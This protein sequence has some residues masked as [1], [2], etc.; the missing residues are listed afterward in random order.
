M[1]DEG[2][3]ETRQDGATGLAVAAGGR[4]LVSTAAALDRRL[5]A[6]DPAAK[7]RAPLRRVLIDCSEVAALDTV[8]AWLMLRLEA[9]FGRTGA[10][11]SIENLPPRFAPLLAQAERYTAAT[12][13]PAR[14]ARQSEIISAIEWVGR[15]AIAAWHEV[16]AGFS[17]FGLVTLTTLRI[18]R[19][20]SRFRFT[21]FVSHVQ[22]TGLSALPIVG[23][24]SFLIGVV[25]AY[26]G[27]TQLR[28]FGAEIFTVNLLGIGYLRELG[29]LMTAIIV[30]GRSGSSFTAEIGTMRVN[31]EVDAMTTLGLDPIEV[32][33]VPRLAALG[34]AL[35]LLTFYANI[36]GL[37]G[38]AFIC[39]TALG[40][41]LP[42][43]LQQLQS[44][45]V[46]WTFWLGIFKAPFF[47][48]C[49][50]LIGCRD[51]LRVSRSAE[52]VGR[53][54]TM[55]VVESIFLVIVFDAAFS[56]LFSELNI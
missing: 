14:G 44:S 34:V 6:L 16:M 52:S 30:A 12:A 10:E 5:A 50:A 43:F 23:L 22:R 53:L 15:I 32:L 55:S 8:G 31:E 35:P 42:V 37:I 39:D 45:V 29:V 28:Y 26:Q 25:I 40:I 21:S 49:I 48:M 9:L 18:L 13:M 17:F 54:T 20:P 1:A 24:L 2:W 11:V 41:P 7:T 51:G 36:T 56:I 46:G 33:V 38:G 19:H 27:A 47:A 3:I 4:W